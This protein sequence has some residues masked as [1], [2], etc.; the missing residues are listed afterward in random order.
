MRFSALMLGALL[1]VGCGDTGDGV[2]V[3]GTGGSGSGSGAGGSGAGTGGSAQPT[4]LDNDH[5]GVTTCANDCNDNDA[6]VK[7]G[8]TETLN[9]VDDDCDGK[10]DNH[11]LHADFDHDG[12]NFGDTDCNDDEALVGPF[13]IED[14]A[15][16]IDDNCD[17]NVDE[18]APQCEGALSGSTAADYAKAIGLC[19]FVTGSNFVTGSPNARNIRAS[20]GNGFTPKAGAQMVFLSTGTAKDDKE[21]PTYNPQP[22]TQFGTSGAHP[23]WAKPKCGPAI[24]TAPSANDMTEVD[25]TI[26]VPQN[27][28]SFSYEFAFF[29]AEYP[30]Y[31]C[32]KYNDR[33]I[34]ILESKGLD[35]TKLPPGQ[36]V[37][38][39]SVPTCNVSYDG[40]GQ[41]VT[42]NNG[43][44]DVCDS[45]TGKNA[46]YVQ[47]TNTCT[48]SSS[49]LAMTGYDR[50]DSVYSN[51]VGGSTGW[52]K[53]SAPVV[54][55]E[56]IKIR[57]II[58]DEGD[59]KYDSSVLIDNFKWD[60][61]A[62]SAPV[63]EEP[64]IN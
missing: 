51:K 56:T 42:I 64:T 53:T 15:N 21:M 20:F 4:C 57:F 11:I 36:C 22:G 41:P 2:K 45:F 10:V 18:A 16:K 49:L 9:Q 63:T 29:S 26:Q 39:T 30:E 37:G 32:T 47:I 33:F 1:A 3:G 35:T 48:K 19:G 28:K 52:L 58:L 38:G 13:A 59:N 62:I 24:S 14:D 61:Q 23:L 55:G 8:A 17:G 43:F 40:Q 50:S 25:F 54:P 46:D 6:N 31:V 12:S 27:A 34:A 7:P 44:F 5:D 60:I